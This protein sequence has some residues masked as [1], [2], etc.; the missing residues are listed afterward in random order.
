M[1]LLSIATTAAGLALFATP[2]AAITDDFGVD[3]YMSAPTVQGTAI[4]NGL[5]V[6]NF[7]VAQ[8]G[9]PCPSS[10]ALGD[11]T[12]DCNVEVAGTY[13]G[14]TADGDDPMPTTG[15]SGSN[16][17]STANPSMEI[18]ISL[19]ESAKYLGLWW[20]AGSPS[21]VVELYA[22]DERVAHMS[23]QTLMTLLEA[24]TATSVGGTQY[25]TDDYYGNPRN[26]SLADSEPFLYL[27][28]YGTG[29]A[30]FD[31]IVLS[32][33]GFEFDNIAVSDL[34]QAPGDGEV[35]VE[36][37]E[38]ENA[39]AEVE[40]SLADTGFTASALS[41]FGAALLAVG[42]FTVRRRNGR[43]SSAARA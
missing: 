17:A 35:G 32:G 41:S 12:G 4:T 33:G 16:Y 25:D 5:T 30:S 37:I 14:A 31:R 27:N 1:R 34:Q 42:A 23:T 11:I 38:G 6:E 20:S 2:S 13:G 28:L 9:N 8:T 36:F 18:T 43:R 19:N 22:G 3:I 7:N 15:G 10:I 24:G 21:N 40:D 39:P 29:G 26:R